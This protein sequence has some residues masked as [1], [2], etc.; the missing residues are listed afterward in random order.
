[1]D[2]GASSKSVPPAGLMPGARI[3]QGSS[4]PP[5]PLPD[6]E[7]LRKIGEGSYGEVWLA[8]NMMGT[9]RAVKIVYRESFKDPRPFERE[10]SGINKF[11]PISRS[12]EG[13][14]DVLQAGINEPLG[15]FYYV[16]EL[17]DD[18]ASGQKIDPKNYSPK[19]LAKAIATRGKLSVRETLE[20]GLALSLALG[21]LHKNGLVHRDIKPSNIIFV[22][23]V[24]KLADI[25]LVAELKEARSYVGTEGFIPPE[26]PGTP[27]AD[28][29]GLGK[30]LYEACTGKDRQD[31]P[32]LPTLVDEFSD[33]DLFLELNEVLIQACNTEVSRRYSS[34]WAMHADLLVLANGKSVKRLRLLERRWAGVKRGTGILALILLVLTGLGYGAYRERKT[35]ME[36]RQRQVASNL[37]L[38]NRALESGDLLG[39]L[40][41]FAEALHLDRGNVD[42]EMEHRLRFGSTHAQCAKIV[43]M[44]FE[45]GEVGSIGF[46]P[47]NRG[48]LAIERHG[49]AQVF[50]VETGQP[51]SPRFGQNGTLW[52]G[53]FSP[54]GNLAAT[55]S[56]DRTVC[57]WRVSDGK[58]LLCLK[59][60]N[61]LLSARFSPDG[62]R[63]VTGCYDNIVRIWDA[64]TGKLQLELRGH[65][66]HVRYAAFSPDSVR[67]DGGSSPPAKTAQPEYGMQPTVTLW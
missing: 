2:S 39:S 13:F 11:E 12:H 8:K 24:P 37:G 1:M 28:V 3:A 10:L 57:I 36:L 27:Q 51:L 31:F 47:D 6:H 26:G 18:E 17:G 4:P 25:G 45:P 46:S 56:E 29:Y 42:R 65:T 52:H 22:N 61:K 38:G 49:K 40:P 55:A 9:Y 41:Y 21:E 64:Q 44:W 33:Q 32:V 20:L 60:P 59:H 34:A 23:G 5:L 62:S 63:L 16:M 54:D 14:V 48:V 35:E 7:L 30:V 66:Q 50:D 15:C 43:Q 58:N 19:T 67:T 53:A